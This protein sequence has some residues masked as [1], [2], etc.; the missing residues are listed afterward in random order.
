MRKCVYYQDEK[1]K[2]WKRKIYDTE[3]S[4]FICHTPQGDLYKKR[5]S[6]QSFYVWG[7]DGV[8]QDITWADAN[9]L[10]KTFGDRDTHLKLFTTL[11]AST[12]QRDGNTTQVRIDSYHRIKAWRNAERLNLSLQGYIYRLIDR[13]DDNHNYCK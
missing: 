9:N 11:R 10:T 3:K 4:M 7:T 5:G 13:D 2:K 8:P 6:S 1:D 12:D